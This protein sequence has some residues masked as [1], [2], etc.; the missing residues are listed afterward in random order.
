[1]SSSRPLGSG[2]SVGGAARFVVVD[3]R[4]PPI[5]I[6]TTINDRSGDF[7]LKRREL[8]SSFLLLVA[9]ISGAAALVYETVWMR[10]FRLAFGSTSQAVSATLCAY[11][12]GLAIGAALFGRLSGRTA[13]P[14]RLYGGVELVAAAAALLVPLALHGYGRIY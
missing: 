5:S 14:L 12:L 9:S 10:W 11:F 1:L 3:R 13:R 2:S 8:P 4:A 7:P 6:V